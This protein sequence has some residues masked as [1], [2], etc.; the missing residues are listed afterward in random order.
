MDNIKLIHYYKRLAKII[1]DKP[2]TPE[3]VKLHL[4]IQSAIDRLYK[5]A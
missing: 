5:S 3:R 4:K 1:G 2:A